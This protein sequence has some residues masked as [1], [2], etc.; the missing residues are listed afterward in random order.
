[1]AG[2]RPPEN[3]PDAPGNAKPAA[4]S[5]A[6]A[7]PEQQKEA[8]NKRRLEAEQFEAQKK[9]LHEVY[10]RFK[11]GGSRF[12]QI[13]KVDVE[14]IGDAK[15]NDT[16]GLASGNQY[17]K[18]KDEKGPGYY[19]N[20]DT[21]AVVEITADGKYRPVISPPPTFEK[22][23]KGL[24]AAME[25]AKENGKTEIVYDIAN[26]KYANYKEMEYVLQSAAAKGL[27]VSFGPNVTKAFMEPNSS[28][29]EYTKPGS[30]ALKGDM[31]GID[32]KSSPIAREFDNNE[33]GTAKKRAVFEGLMDT[34]KK[35]DDQ[36]DAKV[37]AKLAATQPA[38]KTAPE[39]V[40][41]KSP[42]PPSP[43]PAG[44]GS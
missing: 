27:K 3:T 38:A 34:K 28:F 22:R 18:D 10:P 42:P 36:I 40:A 26:P 24:D 20:L 25:L 19:Q 31:L 21:K 37:N 15:L 23:C 17:S 2:S 35:N 12:K 6:A 8:D 14:K 16:P 33:Q 43:R 7:V 39:P 5:P 29:M 9:A 1:M 13:N 41:A 4:T 30:S 11:F 44:S 32:K